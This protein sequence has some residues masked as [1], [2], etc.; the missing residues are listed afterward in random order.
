[1]KILVIFTGG[2]IGSTV[3]K[4]W[5]VT[6]DSTKYMLLDNYKYDGNDLE[7]VTASPYTALSENLSAN[8]LNL[9]QRA[10]GEG[11]ATDVDGIIVTHGTDTL[12]YA[13]AAVEYAFGNSRLP[14]VLVSSDYPLEDERTNGYYNFDAAVKLIGSGV[15]SGVYVSYRNND[16][17]VTDI[18][19][20]SRILRHGE[21]CPNLYSI[22]GKPYAYYDG[23]IILNGVKTASI[24]NPL[25]EVAYSLDS[26]ILSIDSNPGNSYGYSL[27]GI[28]AV[29]LNPYHSATLDTANEK[30]HAFCAQANEAGIPVFVSNVKSG[31]SYEST[32]LFEDLGVI[33]L[34]YGTYISA[35][36]KIWAAISLGRN[37]REMV[38]T[39]IANEWAE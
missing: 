30:L 1:M 17:N 20:A 34:P 7:F 16:S 11:L 29:I 19:L 37:V 31:I 32:K 25:G 33:S 13:A 2:T 6:D 26:G 14:I 28:K 27:K 5:M 3:K 12:Q 8:E 18:H 10:V 24:C 38:S 39:P 35:Y 23:E 21:C 4:G 9:L 22:D 36:V 15:K